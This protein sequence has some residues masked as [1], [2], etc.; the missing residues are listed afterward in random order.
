MKRRKKAKSVL[1]RPML[2]LAVVLL[3]VGITLNVTA[4][5]FI[6]DHVQEYD[7]Y[8]TVG[9]IVGFNVDTWAIFFGTTSPGGSSSRTINVTNYGETPTR[10]EFQFLGDLARITA[11]S[12]TG[13][14]VMPG[15]HKN[16]TV[17]AQVP[18]DMPYGNYTGKMRILY[19]E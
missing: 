9:N 16:V 12:A 8:L 5:L 18:A 7:M 6:P 13:F 1:R 4:V 11:V 3:V 15:E 10:V 19:F 17:Q 2:V 14:T